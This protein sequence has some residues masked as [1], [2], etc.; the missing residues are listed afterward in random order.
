[1]SEP[2]N[3]RHFLGVAASTSLGLACPPPGPTRR[4]PVQ[5][6]SWVSWAPA[7]GARPWPMASSNSPASRSP[8]SATLI[9]ARAERAAAVGAK[10]KRPDARR[11]S[12][13]S[14]SILDDK[15][16]DAGDRRHLQSLARP[17]RHPGLRG[18]QACLRREAVQPQS[19]ARANCW[20]RRPASTR[21]HVQMGNQR[22]SWPKIIEA[23]AAGARR[24]HRPGLPRPV[25]VSRT[26]GP[27]SARA[28]KPRS[29]DG[30]DYDLWQ[31][32]APRRP[33]HSNYLH[34]N[35]HWFWH[36]GNGELGNNGIHMIDLCRW[37]LGVDYPDRTSPP[38]AAA[39]ATRTIRKRPDTHIVNFDFEGRKTIT[40]EGLSCT[41]LPGGKGADVIF[42]GDK[43]SLMINGNGYTIHDPRARRSA[44][45]PAPAAMPC[46]PATCW[47]RS[48]RQA[49]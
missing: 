9:R 2:M 45:K 43:G 24:G 17:R 6:L 14:A 4:W 37:G 15:T 10:V 19:R 8:M 46:T 35:W 21:R 23:I 18:R 38:R 27:P 12:A 1:M 49:P 33:F 39:S 32:P 7:V 11:P 44:R 26:T 22:R 40:W 34:Y 20:S 42:V 28:R 13:T 30:L 31:G 5:K 36:W 48:V 41:S 47:T 16:V 3:R 25:V 29:P